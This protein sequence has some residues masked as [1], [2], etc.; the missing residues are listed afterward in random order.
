[1]QDFTHK[2]NHKYKEIVEKI[3]NKMNSSRELSKTVVFVTF[4][5]H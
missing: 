2:K 1:M 3:K 4:L 5:T